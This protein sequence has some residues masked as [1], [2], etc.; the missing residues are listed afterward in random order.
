LV[1]VLGGTYYNQRELERIRKLNSSQDAK[2]STD[3]IAP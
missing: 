3:D 2:G 1:D